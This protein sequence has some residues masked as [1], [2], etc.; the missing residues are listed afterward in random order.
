VSVF[1][2]QCIVTIPCVLI[3]SCCENVNRVLNAGDDL[4]MNV[5]GALFV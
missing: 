2:L 4:C 5:S 3:T 1:L